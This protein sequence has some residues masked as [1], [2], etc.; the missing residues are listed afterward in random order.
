[1]ILDAGP[2]L[3]LAISALTIAVLSCCRNY[4]VNHSRPPLPPGPTPLPV[5]GN[6]LS[7]DT[8]RPWL[9]FNAWR[10]TYGDMIYARLLSK[11][12]LVINSEEVAK[13]LFEGRSSIYSDRTQSI[14]YEAFATDFNMGFMPY[15]DR[16]RL[17]RRLLHQAFRQ[18]EIPTYHA[19]QIR[20]AHQML[21]SLLQDPGNHASH[22]QMFILSSVLSMIYDCE[23]K[24]KD[25]HIV[26]A[27]TSYAEMVADGLAPA[28][29][30]LM[31]TFPF[32]LQLPSWFPGAIF[33]RASVKCI[34]AGHDV[35]EIPFQH[36]KERMVNFF[37]RRSF[38]VFSVIRNG[39]SPGFR[40]PII[41]NLPFIQTISLLRVFLLAMVLNPEV[42]GKAH[43]EINR[44]V[45][46]NRLP[47]FNDRPALPYVEAVLRET[48]RWHPVTPFGVPHAT[49]TSDVYNG[50]FIPKGIFRAMTHDP[51][52]YPSPDE[53][54][55]ERFLHEDGSLTSDTM[56]LAFGW[57]RRICVGR[58]VAEASSW[59][60]IVNFLAFFSA[61]K[62]LDEQG[63]DI[64]VDPKFSTGFAIHPET[65]PCRILPRFPDAPMKTLTYLTGLNPYVDITSE[66]QKTNIQ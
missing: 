9:T 2:I 43:A 51:K 61:H 27:V 23:A 59:I 6:F 14:V 37:P 17:H 45:G 54:K 28:A 65:F 58:H 22:F 3:Y 60:A 63:M 39:E 35:K 44:V 48:L 53:F 66:F 8:A 16:W 12:V 10:S 21:F 40:W 4:W 47:D 52:K 62:D 46:K 55:P 50:Y 42:Q 56:S 36:V 15:G 19:V 1:M 33:K 24:A 41:I 7:L 20:S 49:T 11:P 57:G 25:D 13:D 5:L 26:H 32:L 34:Q 64:P 29:M 18:A 30:M 31:E 38:I